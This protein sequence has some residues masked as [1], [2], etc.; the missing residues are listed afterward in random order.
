[1]VWNISASNSLNLNLCNFSSNN[2]DTIP[3][4]VLDSFG[5]LGLGVEFPK[6][7]LDI[8][9]NIKFSGHLMPNG[10]GGDSGAVMVSRGLLL[11]PVWDNNFKKGL[12][13]DLV[14][15]ILF[16]QKNVEIGKT[17]INLG[18][19]SFEP[20]QHYFNLWKPNINT[21][22]DLPPFTFTG[23]EF[24][25]ALPGQPNNYVYNFGSNINTGGGLVEDGKP[26]FGLGFENRF[27]I[28]QKPYNEF[29]ILAIDENGIQR[30]P[31]TNIYAFDGSRNDWTNFLSSMKLQDKDGTK[32]VYNINTDS[33]NWTYSGNGLRHIFN[34]PNYQP[35]WQNIGNGVSFPLIG[36]LPGRLQLGNPTGLVL[37]RI[38]QGL[39][40][41]NDGVFD[42]LGSALGD[43]ATNFSLG[44][45]GK[46]YNTIWFKTNFEI[47][48]R[49][50]NINNI[51]G[52]GFGLDING[53]MYFNDFTSNT[54]PFVLDANMPNNSFRMFSNG[55]ICLGGIDQSQKLTVNGNL[56]V[57]GSF[58]PDNIAGVPGEVLVSQGPSSP[59]L[60][61][62]RI[63]GRY[64]EAFIAVSGQYEFVI[65][66]SFS[67]PTGNEIPIE[68]YKGGIKLKYNQGTLGVREFNYTNNIITT[69]PCQQDDEVEI[70]YFK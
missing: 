37:M 39:E 2:L 62:T 63:S 45:E 1:L 19:Y 8:S 38:G 50:T 70:V 66:A 54:T 67:P 15:K 64:E 3:K 16:D 28:D 23:G 6:E 18:D 17:L 20:G 4:V 13:Q 51:N 58:M 60:W 10:I 26:G 9:G 21:T 69:F 22:P 43:G 61:G 44:T 29:H 36:Y 59:P 7:K 47:V 55:N 48:S 49:F 33:E 27:Y 34:T 57:N 25:N 52:W 31:L 30:R 56:K 42:Y 24:P 46:R 68:V 32:E 53:R 41:G 11:P 65:N 40:L 12:W 14:D 5:R 35:I